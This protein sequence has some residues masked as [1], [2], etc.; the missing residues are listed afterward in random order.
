MEVL[1]LLKQIGMAAAYAAQKN[2]LTDQEALQMKNLQKEWIPNEAVNV[3]YI[4]RYLDKLYKCRQN[5]TTQA[6]WT[7]DVY[8]AGWEVIDE[9]HLGTKEDPIPWSTGMRP[10]LG[11]YY[12]EGDLI[13]KCIED[14]LIALYGTL[15][16]LC[17]GRY[18]EV[19]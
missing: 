8:Q 11:K 1:D 7:P 9:E 13:A 3:G 15:A 5:H 18:F 17:P 12:V 4:R 19:G 10:E 2:E 14:P 6:N 16:E